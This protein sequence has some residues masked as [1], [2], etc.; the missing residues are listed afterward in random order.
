M[1]VQGLPSGSQRDQL[2]AAVGAGSPVHAALAVSVAPSCATPAIAGASVI[3]GGVAAPAGAAARR[4]PRTIPSPSARGVISAQRQ[5]RFAPDQRPGLA[6]RSGGV[7]RRTTGFRT[8][9]RTSPTA[10]VA[11]AYGRGGTRAGMGPI[12]RRAKRNATIVIVVVALIGVILG[13]RALR[14]RSRGPAGAVVRVDWSRHGA[15]VPPSFLGVSVEWDSVVPYVGPRRRPYPGLGRVLA[16]VRRAAG[17]PLALRIGGYMATQAKGDASH[18][19]R[20][21]TVAPGRRARA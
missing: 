10:A 15:V 5:P 14:P 11:W 20:P 7:R 13:A 4:R 8:R 3:T 2:Q 1:T 16:P 21:P 9:E 12:P 19:A 17:T 18:P 6:R